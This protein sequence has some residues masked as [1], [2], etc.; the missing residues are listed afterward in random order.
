MKIRFEGA[1]QTVTGSQTV[2]SHRGYTSLVDC[3]LYQAP[4]PLRL[5]NLE[6]PTYFSDINSIVLTHA[7]IDHSGLLPRWSY[8]GWKGPV[9]C[10]HSTADLL[11]IMLLDAA[12]LQEEDALFANKTRHSRHDPALPL[13]TTEDARAALKLLRP[14]PFDQ[15]QTLSSFMSFRFLRAGHILGSA[16]VQ[17]AYTDEQRSKILTFSGDLGGGHSDL[18]ND[19]TKGLESDELVLESTYGDRQVNAEGRESRLADVVN[20]VIGRNGTLVIPAFALGRTQDLLFSLYRLIQKNLIPDVPVYLDSP[21]ANAVTKVYQ[22]HLEELSFD[23]SNNHIVEALSTRNFHAVESPDESMLLRTSDEPKIVLSASGML[24]GGRVLHHLKQKLPDAKNG[25]LFVGFQGKGT[26]GRLLQEKI[27]SIRIHHQEIPVAAEIFSLEGY[28]AHGDAND[29]MNWLK[30][31]RKQPERIFLN[32]GEIE[33][34]TIFAE[35][36][37]KE[38]GINVAIPQLHEEFNLSC[39]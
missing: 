38:F 18:L 17:F 6:K 35:R 20:K 13:Y 15:W 7:H 14:L 5:L 23:P 29:L 22:K 19:P 11:S 36:I 28:S 31:F 30:S 2:V 1:A 33:A 25:V 34:Q 39:N 26:K 27:P 12:K 8:W 21:M 37:R 9:Y 3:G 10:T 16:I 32:H 4:K 24:Q